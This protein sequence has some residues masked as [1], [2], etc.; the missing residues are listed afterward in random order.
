MCRK[1]EAKLNREIPFKSFTMD[2]TVEADFV[3]LKEFLTDL[4][5]KESVYIVKNVTI[6]QKNSKPENLLI[7]I[8]I[9]YI[10]I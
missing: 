2:L 3:S 6:K 10:E 9:D 8:K 7:N 4:S 5:Q 1:S